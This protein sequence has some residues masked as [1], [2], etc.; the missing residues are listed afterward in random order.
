VPARS[1][2]VRID[3]RPGKSDKNE[4]A[5]G[6]HVVELAVPGEDVWRRRVRITAGQE[7]FIQ[8]HFVNTAAR[9]R[10]EH[11]GFA[12]LAGA[13]ALLVTGFG[14]ALVSEHASNEARDIQR[15]ESLRDPS[16][17]IDGS[18]EPVRTRA[19]FDAAVSRANRDAI[20]SDIAYGAGAVA[21]GVA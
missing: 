3:S 17:P 16:Q 1:G 12:I 20:I 9:E 4:L 18:L 14:F 19:D 6:T 13:G 7:T 11:V 5:P 10:D 21:V 15:V 8:P 2:D